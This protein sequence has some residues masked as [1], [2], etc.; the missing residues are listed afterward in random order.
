MHCDRLACMSAES[1][2]CLDKRRTETAP[3]SR[4]QYRLNETAKSC[5]LAR[6]LHVEV[7]RLGAWSQEY[8]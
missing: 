2:T 4:L 1:A 3:G 5:A 6:K 8:M 7:Y